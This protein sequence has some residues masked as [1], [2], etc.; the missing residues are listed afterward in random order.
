MTLYPDSNTFIVPTQEI[1][2]DVRKNGK[3]FDWRG[4]KVSNVYYSKILDT[5]HY[6][7][8]GRVR[9]CA[10]T[11]EFMENDDGT[12][13]LSRVWFC[14]SKLCPVCN[15]R[16][17]MKLG[18][19]NGEILTEAI[20]Q[21][22]NARFLFLTLTVKNVY[23]GDD[24]KKLLSS[25]TKG[26]NKLFRYKKVDQNLIGWLRSTEITINST[27]N[28]YHPHIHV[29]LMVKSTYFKND[30]NYISQD[31]WTKL[32]K[33][34]LKINYDPIVDIRAVK[35][36]TGDKSDTRKAVL[37]TSK[38][39]VKDSDYITG[40][41]AYDARIIDDLEQALFRKR[42]IAYGKLFKKI[43]HEL[44]LDD[45]EDGDLTEISDEDEED[46]D[47]QAARVIAKFDY[48][49]LNYYVAN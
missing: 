48:L 45:V 34:A 44:Q 42:Q 12:L 37:E 6:L 30:D 5:L 27:D 33:K 7:K 19:Q 4:R 20:K 24:L 17:S 40:E 23:G 35:G 29:L 9:D 1:F 21:E 38:Y 26:F 14:K 46:L 31:E 8:A 41:V 18:Y 43:R 22:P 2:H 39:P 10:D 28:S 15:W 49:R 25:M 11:L 16:R 47:E 32:W 3:E 36:K 13:R